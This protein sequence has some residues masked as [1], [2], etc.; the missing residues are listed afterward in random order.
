MSVSESLMSVEPSEADPNM[1]LMSQVSSEEAANI[2]TSGASPFSDIYVNEYPYGG[3]VEGNKIVAKREPAPVVEEM[4]AKVEVI[5]ERPDVMKEINELIN[6]KFPGIVAVPDGAPVGVLAA[7][8]DAP[9][10]VPLPT[11][12]VP[13]VAASMAPAMSLEK[14][15]ENPAA[16]DVEANAAIASLT[17]TR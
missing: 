13:Q 2:P 10:V 5:T 17:R 16:S 1:S 6:G 9:S 14:L 12:L 15:T 7:D 4:S 3:D 11:A 8:V